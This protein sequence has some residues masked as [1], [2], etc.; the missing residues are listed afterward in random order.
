MPCYCATIKTLKQK[1]ADL[2]VSLA[3]IQEAVDFGDKAKKQIDNAADGFLGGFSH[4][5][6][7]RNTATSMCN[8]SSDYANAVSSAKSAVESELSDA[9]TS[10]K[11]YEGLD[12]EYHERERLKA[13]ARQEARKSERQTN[14]LRV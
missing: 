12:E 10:L 1:I 4:V 6:K 9:A 2:Q 3:Y 13:L 7:E 11:Y 14:M 5:K 8:A